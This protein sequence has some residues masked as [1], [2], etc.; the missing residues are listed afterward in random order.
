MKLI[1]QCMALVASLTLLTACSKESAPGGPGASQG[2]AEPAA[3]NMP[4][5]ST[6]AARPAESATV[7]DSAQT[8]TLKVPSATTHIKRGAND[9]VTLSISRGSKFDQAV[10]LHLTAPQGVTIEPASATIEPGQSE[11]KVTLTAAADAPLGDQQIKVSATPQT[12]KAVDEMLT[13]KIDE[14]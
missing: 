7:T 9:Q 1:L 11:V 6:E 10:T 13:V 2:P 8:F 4:S 5:T 12:G 3:D 14:K